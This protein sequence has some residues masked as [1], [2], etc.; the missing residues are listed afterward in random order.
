MGQ[1]RSNHLAMISIENKI[2]A[3]LNI[4]DMRLKFSRMKA[5]KVQFSR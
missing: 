1:E 5:R 3:D 4:K 2:A